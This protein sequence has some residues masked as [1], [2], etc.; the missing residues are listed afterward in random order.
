MTYGKVLGMSVLFLSIVLFSTLALDLTVNQLYPEAKVVPING[1]CAGSNVPVAFQ[2]TKGVNTEW[3]TQSVADGEKRFAVTFT[4][5]AVGNYTVYVACSSES[6]HTDFCI[7]AAEQCSLTRAASGVTEGTTTCTA[8]QCRRSWG[9]INAGESDTFDTQGRL[10]ITAVKFTALSTMTSTPSIEIKQLSDVPRNVDPFQQT[11]YRLYEIRT[12]PL[13]DTANNTISFRVPKSWLAE[14][15]QTPADVKLFR[16]ANDWNE[17]STTLSRQ[18]ATYQ[19]Y[20]AQTLAFSYFIIGGKKAVA[21][22]APTA[23]VT[24]PRRDEPV[25]PV[26]PAPAPVAPPPP[27]LSCF[28]DIRNQG[29][30]AVD[31]GGPCAPCATCSDGIQNQGEQGLD[32]GGPCPL[33]VE[34]APWYQDIKIIGSV[35]VIVVL[36]IALAVV[37]I[38][39]KRGAKGELRHI[40]ELRSYIQE[41]LSA[42]HTEGEVRRAVRDAGWSEDEMRKA[43]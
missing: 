17:L 33:C 37:F 31:C 4:P 3:V 34:E 8:E 10:E 7:G 42:G 39:K 29:E 23:P 38:V 13:F 14:K 24:P 40:N 32:C 16:F 26:T 36:L 2:V 18:D 27:A 12:N 25:R 5:Q 1:T 19:Y 43:F 28:D 21:P 20:E 9:R 35:A 41:Q 22:A 6:K 30:T 15:N 11:L